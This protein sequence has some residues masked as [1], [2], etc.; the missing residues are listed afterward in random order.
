MGLVKAF[1]A[2]LFLVA[3]G[4]AAEEQ[5]K[6][7]GVLQGTQ[8]HS[9]AGYQAGW[10]VAVISAAW[11]ALEPERGKINEVEIGK[12]RDKAEAF[13]ALGY[14]LQLDLGIQYPPSWI[15]DFPH[16]RYRNQFGAGYES[17]EPG[18]RMANAVFNQAVR[19]R[20]RWYIEQ[21]FT[22]L[23]TDWDWVRLGGGFYGEVNF[24][25]HA[26]Q[27]KTNA[28]WAFDDLAQGRVS[29]LAKGLEA[30]PVA[31]WMPGEVSAGNQPARQF[32]SWYH[33]A[34]QH[35]HDWQIRTVRQWYRGEICMLYG[36]WGIRPGWIEAALAQ[37][38]NGSSVGERNGEI[39]TG[40]DWERMVGGIR[41]PKVIVYCTWIDAPRRDCDDA[42]GNRVR[43]SPVHWLSSLAA[44]NPLRLKVWGENTGRNTRDSMELTFERVQ[45]FGLMGVMWAFE[46]DLFAEPNPRNY[47]TF[48]DFA[49]CIMKAHAKAASPNH[50]H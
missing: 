48:Q 7:F 5:G 23:G 17:N 2:L 31:G 25:H 16:S 11:N 4:L 18:K 24:P 19:E 42:G 45:Q 32:L 27:G 41:D 36:S 22:Q 15:F 43:W 30:C 35:Y 10:R 34:L 50:T 33:G 13:R 38:L 49:E 8:K 21:V 37:D 28:Y 44:A 9:A 39:A 20:I 47:A 3:S 40:Y 14:R 46:D 12:L 26:Y 6:L 1:G 29:G